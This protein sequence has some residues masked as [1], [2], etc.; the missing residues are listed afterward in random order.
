MNVRRFGFA[1]ALAAGSCFIMS[2]S[3]CGGSEGVDSGASS[4]THVVVKREK[5]GGG[6]GGGAN[7]IRRP[8]R[9]AVLSLLPR[10][11]WGRSRER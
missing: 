10:A 4:P 3:G 1:T 11:A 5:A 7:A 9:P 6:G 2:L 8:P